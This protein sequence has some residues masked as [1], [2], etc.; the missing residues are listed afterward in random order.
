MPPPKAAPAHRQPATNAAR[1]ELASGV[2]QSAG[3]SR[4]VTPSPEALSS[5][6]QHPAGT[7]TAENRQADD[8]AEPSKASVLKRAGYSAADV[9]RRGYTGDLKRLGYSKPASSRSQGISNPK[10]KEY[11]IRNGQGISNPKRP[12]HCSGDSHPA[13]A[14][15]QA[16]SK[17]RRTEDHEG[18]PY[19]ATSRTRCRALVIDRGFGECTLARG[20]PKPAHCSWDEISRLQEH[21]CATM[22]VVM[23]M[24]G[25]DGDEW[26][27]H[28]GGWTAVTTPAR[29]GAC[30]LLL[31]PRRWLLD[32]KQVLDAGGEQHR[33]V[34]YVKLRSV[35][36]HHAATSC[37]QILV[38]KNH[39][40][41]PSEGQCFYSNIRRSVFQ[42]MAGAIDSDRPWLLVGDLGCGP[43]AACFY[44][45]HTLVRSDCH[46]VQDDTNTVY[47]MGNCL[48]LSGFLFPDNA[49][50]GAR[51]ID[52]IL[53]APSG[54]TTSC[55]SQPAASST[56]S[57][58][59][60]A[61][62]FLR[63]LD[64]AED[65]TLIDTLA[66]LMFSE[67]AEKQHHVEVDGLPLTAASSHSRRLDALDCCLSTLRDARKHALSS[68]GR[69]PAG[70]ATE[71]ADNA[72]SLTD[73]Q[74]EEAW[75]W[76][77]Q[78][79]RNKWMTNQDIRQQLLDKDANLLNRKEK[80]AANK[81]FLGAFRC[82]FKSLTGNVH[83]GR[84]ILRHGFDSPAEMKCLLAEY[85][86]YIDSADY[87]Q[88]L[89]GQRERRR[90]TSC[91]REEAF[92]ARNDFKHAQWLQRQ[93]NQD[94]L[95]EQMLSDWQRQLML[96]LEL[97]ELHKRRRA[98]NIAYGHGAGNEDHVL[99]REAM[100]TMN[101]LYKGFPDKK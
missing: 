87:T 53:G 101:A 35:D 75:T 38:A 47:A 70:T 58:V 16:A 54:S 100:L 80:S 37:V 39:R 73:S 67:F 97:G 99:S 63:R 81:S 27:N 48:A 89:D 17:R 55:V 79:F 69:H 24:D 9:M 78:E 5:G 72:P 76:L 93:L 43:F 84:A 41:I 50:S 21:S 4:K 26:G 85:Y 57:L 65:D 90:S 7:A 28:F 36:V 11:R 46:T 74:F 66:D 98:A 88:W 31:D 61:E 19:E 12:N 95:S 22:I 13:D 8:K 91:L 2:Q 92:R 23:G 56:L 10:A 49:D 40:G 20:V 71:A 77:K 96:Q 14:S 33:K 52:W 3:R 1:Q 86:K 68:G 64:A 82:F 42:T 25:V 30:M 62:T 29:S 44:L 15:G 60:R 94:L 59:S 18:A 34:I 6:G 45:G 51:L 32:L 83:V